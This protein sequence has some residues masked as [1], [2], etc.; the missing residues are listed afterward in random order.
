MIHE[1]DQDDLQYFLAAILGIE[2]AHLPELAPT[3]EIMDAYKKH[4]E[5]WSHYEERFRGLLESR[6]PGTYLKREY[7]DPACRSSQRPRARQRDLPLTQDIPLLRERQ[8]GSRHCRRT[9]E[10][11]G[12]GRRG[13]ASVAEL[14]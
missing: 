9:G 5:D 13:H 8:Q 6:G 11:Q 2:Y 3:G 1:Y 4:G 14:E 12:P 10:R 7:L